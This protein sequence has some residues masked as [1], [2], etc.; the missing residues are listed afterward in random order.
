MQLDTLGFGSGESQPISKLPGLRHVRVRTAEGGETPARYGVTDDDTGQPKGLSRFMVQ[1]GIRQH[2][3]RAQHALR[4]AEGPVGADPQPAQRQ[5]HCPKA[6]GPGMEP[7]VH[8]AARGENPGRRSARA[9][10]GHELRDAAPFVRGALVLPWPLHLAEQ[11][12]E[13]LLPTKIGPRFARDSG[14]RVGVV[15]LPE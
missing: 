1:S 12:E 15:D 3:G 10:T 14:G 5:A 6:E 13:Y 9:S 2:H 4:S 8:R 7:A 11:I